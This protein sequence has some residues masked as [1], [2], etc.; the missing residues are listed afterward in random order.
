MND[1]ETKFLPSNRVV[2]TYQTFL[3]IAEIDKFTGGWQ[4]TQHLAP[5][6][7]R[8]VKRMATIRSIGASTRIEGTQLTNAEVE[9]LLLRKGRRSFKTRDEQEVAGYGKVMNTVLENYLNV[10]ITEN[11]IK[12]LHSIMLQYSAKDERHRGYYKTLPNRVESLNPTTGASLGIVLETASPFETPTMMAVL[13]SWFNLQID[14]DKQH[15]L[16]LI[17]TFV[18]VFLA[19]H[20]F[21]DGN[22]RISR[23]LTTLLLLKAGYSWVAYSSMESVIEEHQE[24]YYLTLRSTQKTLR[25]KQKDWRPWCIFFVAKAM[26]EQ[27]NNLASLLRNEQALQEKMPSL[28]RAIIDLVRSYGEISVR[29]IVE[30]LDANRNTVRSHLRRLLE[31]KRLRLIGKGRGS[32]YVK[33]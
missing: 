3:A 4:A 11:S 10:P 22:G 27:K 28:S 33:G 31:Q 12:Y 24:H 15:P 21:K 29:E 18:V 13:I 14:D 20:P 9:R 2:P 26:L 1:V 6:R 7:L 25:S 23:V 30:E 8:A 17:A 19:I 16:L 32:R 5:D